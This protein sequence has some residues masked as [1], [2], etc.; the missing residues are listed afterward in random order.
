MKRIRKG[1]LVLALACAAFPFA[2]G[3]RSVTRGVPVCEAKAECVAELYSGRILYEKSGEDKLPMASTTKI[4]T[5]IAVLEK[6][7][8]VRDRF[9]VPTEAVGIEGSSV[10]LKDGE[11]YS[12][13]E[14]LY[15]LMLRSGNDAAV[16]LALHSFGSVAACSVAMNLIAQKAGALNS[17]FLTPHGLPQ[18]GH[19]TTARDLTLITCY[20]LKNPDFAKIV[21]TAYYQPKG[22]KNKNKMLYTYDG[23]IGVKTGY[24]KEA[25]RCLVSAATRGNMTLVCTLLNCSDT[26]GRT[27]ILLNDAFSAYE[28]VKIHAADTP[29]ELQIDGKKYAT[30]TKKDLYYPILEVE[31]EYIVKKIEAET[32]KKPKKGDLVGKIKIYLSNRLLFSENLYKL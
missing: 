19:Y 8:D 25:G 29:V 31:R 17:Q 27:E 28:N 21:S 18:D 4:V 9:P 30:H 10:Y 32:V 24:T 16:A 3:N 1:A 14:L 15:G 5:A 6:E 26:Y 7:K 11:E 13:E 12:T 20:G 2:L 22:W 23:A